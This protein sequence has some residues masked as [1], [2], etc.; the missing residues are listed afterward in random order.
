MNENPEVGW[1]VEEES[2]YDLEE[3]LL[4]YAAMVIE[5]VESMSSTGRETMT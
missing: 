5:V 2:R 3:R 4:D 1:K